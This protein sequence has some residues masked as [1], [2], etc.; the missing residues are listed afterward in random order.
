[1]IWFT[2]DHHFGHRNVITYCAR[3][4]A[5]SDEMNRAMVARYKAAVKPTDTVYF[6][7][8]ICFLPARLGTPILKRLP[9]R[10]LLIKGNHDKWSDT[11]YHE[12]GFELI[13]QELVLTLA[14]Q[15]VRLS[16]YPYAPETPEAAHSM[17]YL[18]RRP[19]RRPNEWLLCGHVHE[20]WKRLGRQINV[21]VDQWDFAPV[22]LSTLESL[23]AHPSPP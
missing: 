7:G 23:W 6:L 2:S 16:H 9:G 12:A 3:P 17:R 21:G 11:Q 19:L 15:R 5:D 18:D 8:D 4:F 20:K 10:K 14:G 1:M 22:S 13:A